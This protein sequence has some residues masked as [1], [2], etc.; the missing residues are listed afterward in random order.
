MFSVS[1]VLIWCWKQLSKRLSLT[2]N[3][4]IDCIYFCLKKMNY[5][6]TLIFMYMSF[7]YVISL[8]ISIPWLSMNFKRWCNFSLFE[9]RVELYFVMFRSS[10]LS[11]S[12]K[13][14]F[15]SKTLVLKRGCWFFHV[16]VKHCFFCF[17]TLHFL[18]HF[19]NSSELFLYFYS[20]FLN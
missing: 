1:K 9:I 7:V 3:L 17:L 18:L 14:K 6:H 16:S 20:F 10:Y 4:F 8:T 2:L 13:A 11:I 15:Q 5:S 12:N 19:L